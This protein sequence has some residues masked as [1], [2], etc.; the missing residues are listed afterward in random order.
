[1]SLVCRVRII[2]MPIKNLEKSPKM[3]ECSTAQFHTSQLF[4]NDNLS[5]SRPLLLLDLLKPKSQNEHDF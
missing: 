3:A 2:K 5:S 4:N 1:M